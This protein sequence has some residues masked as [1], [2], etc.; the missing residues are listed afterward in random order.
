MR[1]FYVRGE[2]LAARAR[3]R[4]QAGFFLTPPSLRVM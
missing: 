1:L 4:R 3:D 2:R